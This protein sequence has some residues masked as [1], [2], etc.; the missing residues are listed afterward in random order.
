MSCRT[1]QTCPVLDTGE[2]R[3]VL[4]SGAC[5][6]PD[7]GFARMTASAANRCERTRSGSRERVWGEGASPWSFSPSPISPSRVGERST[8]LAVPVMTM[9]S[10]GNVF[11]CRYRRQ[12]LAV[13]SRQTKSFLCDLSASAVKKKD[14]TWVLKSWSQESLLLDP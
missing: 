4:D 11:V 1:R 5:P 7:T 14:G 10:G 3:S 12:R 13:K 2:P 9:L 6:G 8:H